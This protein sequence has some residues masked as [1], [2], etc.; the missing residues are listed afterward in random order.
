LADELEDLAKQ[1]AYTIQIYKWYKEQYP[2]EPWTPLAPEVEGS[3]PLGSH[4]FYF[5][6]DAIVSWL[7]HPWLFETK[8]TSQLGPVFFRKFRL[9][10]QISLYI[11]AASKTL[12]IE[13]RGAIINAIRKSR[14]LDR[15]EFAREPVTRTREQVDECVAQTIQQVDIIELLCFRAAEIAAKGDSKR[16]KAMFQMHLNECIRYNRTCDYLELC[17]GQ[18]IDHTDLYG[19][20]VHDYTETE[21]EE[22]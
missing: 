9:D 18:I 4:T 8:T 7:G 17:S 14:K 20:R 11:F 5:R 15:A 1:E 10:P 3:C 13:P 21:G 12:G 22:Q 6:I 2:R 16:A 19:T